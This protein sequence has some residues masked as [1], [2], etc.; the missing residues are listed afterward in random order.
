MRVIVFLKLAANSAA[1]G[2]LPE[3]LGV[4]FPFQIVQL[5]PN[6]LLILQGKRLPPVTDT[7]EMIRDISW[8]RIERLRESILHL[9][10]E[11]V[12]EF[13]WSFRIATTQLMLFEQTRQPL[14]ERHA[15]CP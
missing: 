13:T 12:S 1:D 10:A 2:G 3:H 7:V 15:D 5:M 4:Q 8:D 6:G 9:S 11:A 14:I